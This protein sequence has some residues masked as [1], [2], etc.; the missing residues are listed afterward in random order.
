MKKIYKKAYKMRFNDNISITNIHKYILTNYP[1][2][3]ISRNDLYK[4]LKTNKSR[5]KEKYSEIDRKLILGMYK[6]CYSVEKL[7]EYLKIRHNIDIS[8]GAINS[9]ATKYGVKKDNLN[10]E[11][12]RLTTR[13][14]EKE[15]IYRYKKGESALKIYKDYGYKSTKS[16]YDILKK[17]GIEIRNSSDYINVPYKNFSFKK[18]DSEFKAYFLGLLLSDGYILNNSDTY[19][20]VLSLAIS[21]KD[22]IDFICENTGAKSYTFKAKNKKRTYRVNLYGKELLKDVERLS[23]IERKSKILKKPKLKKSEVTYIPYIIRG[24]IDGDGW[25]NKNGKEF[26]I[27]TASYDFAKWILEELVILGMIELKIKEQFQITKGVPS[28]IYVIRTGRAKNINVL[29]RLIY[30]KPFGMSRKY[31]RLE[32]RSETIIGRC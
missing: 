25:I 28:S 29:K 6:R 32:R 7:L 2:Q 14:Q 30:N 11:H 31:N 27:C 26:F 17:H 4:L 21:D 1:M 12:T 5:A 22:C 8:T 9:M 23:L 10:R 3:N 13:S 19:Q 16:I 24:I 20:Y 15:I 18:I